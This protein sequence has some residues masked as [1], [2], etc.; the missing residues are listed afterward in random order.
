MTLDELRNLVA[1]VLEVDVASIGPSTVFA[2]I[3][4]F[5]SVTR[6]GLIMALDENGVAIA[7]GS[8]GDLK[9]FADVMR[10][11]GIST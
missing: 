3:E 5:D 7:M 10:Y 6:L 2:E 8:V 4:S 9:G 1:G 11:A